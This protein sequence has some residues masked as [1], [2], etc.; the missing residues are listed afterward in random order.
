[1][2]QRNCCCVQISLE[3]DTWS[4]CIVFDRTR[5]NLSRLGSLLEGFINYST[6]K[7]MPITRKKSLPNSGANKKREASGHVITT[8]WIFIFVS[9][10]GGSAATRVDCRWSVSWFSNA[11]SRGWVVLHPRVE[12]SFFWRHSCGRLPLNA[13]SYEL[14]VILSHAINMLHAWC[15][16]QDTPYVS[17]GVSQSAHHVTQ[18]HSG[19]CH[20]RP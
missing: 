13:S 19:H 3:L 9:V 1:M 18:Q 16:V 11:C 5:K 2:L 14:D 6:E 15:I 7:W 8:S 4:P 20:H 10:T 12:Q 17:A